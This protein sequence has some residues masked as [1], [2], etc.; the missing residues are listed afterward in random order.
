MLNCSYLYIIIIT[1]LTDQ[2]MHH[3]N[4]R[5][6]QTNQ[7]TT[8][9]GVA[10]HKWN[11][12]SMPT[13]FWGQ[14]KKSDVCSYEG[15][16]KYSYKYIATWHDLI[17]YV[18]SYLLAIIITVTRLAKCTVHTSAGMRSEAMHQPCIIKESNHDTVK[19]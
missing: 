12:Q 19:A 2:L 15:F 13:Y 1:Y 8:W 11:F 7:Y 14:N 18:H 9:R 3:L 17:G 16:H 6:N 4:H 10:Y 5:C